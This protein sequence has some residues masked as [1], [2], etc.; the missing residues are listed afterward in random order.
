[1]ADKIVNK[2]KS[3][4][5]DAAKKTVNVA[6]KPAEMVLGAV[7]K[8]DQAIH[9]VT[10][11]PIM[12]K[13]IPFTPQGSQANHHVTTVPPKKNEMNKS[14]RDFEAGQK[15]KAAITKKTGVYPNTAD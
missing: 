4:V 8:A 7:N 12:L 2:V 5:V 3:A 10:D 15:A 13:A 1:M 9:K 6:I 14:E 11:K